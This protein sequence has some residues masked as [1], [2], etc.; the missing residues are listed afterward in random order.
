MDNTRGNS[1]NM[2]ALMLMFVTFVGTLFA[3]ALLYSVLTS[4]NHLSQ[5]VLFAGV[6][7]FLAGVVN[8]KFMLFAFVI[9]TAY[10]DLIKRLL[11]LF[12]MP[13]LMDLY[14]V[15]GLAPLTMLGILCGVI[16]GWFMGRFQIEK[17]HWGLFMIATC[18]VLITAA[19]AFRHAGSTI[20]IKRIANASAYSFL[21]FVL[22]V[23]FTSWQE[24]WK[25]CRFALFVFIPVGIYAIYQSIYGL[26]VFE[27]E[28]LESGLTIMVKELRD[29]KPRPFSTMN[30]AHTLAYMAAILMVLAYIPF[31]AGKDNR[32]LFKHRWI[33]G[34]LIV[35]YFA[36]C[37][38]TMAR[39]GHFLW[40][41]AFGGIFAFFTS[42]RTTLFYTSA[43]SAYILMVIFAENLIA[44]LPVW[45]AMLNKSTD[46]L[47]QATRIQTFYDRLYSYSQL[48]QPENYS[49]FGLKH[50]IF[51]HDAI[52][53]SLARFGVVPLAIG[54]FLILSRLRKIHQAISEI[55]SD[56]NRRIA[57]LFLAIAF[58][59]AACDIFFG[60]TAKV[61][62]ISA[63]LWA[64][65]GGA[66]IVVFYQKD[67]SLS[68]VAAI[69]KTRVK[70]DLPHRPLLAPHPAHSA[71][72]APTGTIGKSLSRNHR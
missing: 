38:V 60:G 54:G 61:F 31:A 69:Q 48:K 28:Y 22:P 72:N 42:K 13:N 33:Y 63:Y 15:M 8:P 4:R 24:L 1:S 39:S 19:F 62:P 16:V 2:N 21:I 10:L 64:A 40:M 56:G 25:L 26:S 70:Q 7:S 12:E 29:L 3:V 35:F 27:I 45:D 23:L 52:T 11:I 41:A 71:P 9:T 50:E 67:E 68:E 6:G 58:G 65:I 14:F 32:H 66:L 46:F 20:A 51:T 34:F 17:R 5:L 59:I 30:A 37:F 49:L 36:V 47:A 57:C 43:T 53:E 55:V 18:F 44:K